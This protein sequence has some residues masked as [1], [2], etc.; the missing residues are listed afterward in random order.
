MKGGRRGYP[1]LVHFLNLNNNIPVYNPNYINLLREFNIYNFENYVHFP[2]VLIYHKNKQKHKMII[3]VKLFQEN[4]LK[5]L[6]LKD[7]KS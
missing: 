5:R 7:L 2:S 1:F 3:T 6:F 4:S